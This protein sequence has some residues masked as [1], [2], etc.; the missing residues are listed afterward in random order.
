MTAAQQALHSQRLEYIKANKHKNKITLAAELGMS[1][2][3]VYGMATRYKITLASARKPRVKHAAIL[4]AIYAHPKLTAGKI[5]HKLKIERASVVYLATK[6]N[7]SLPRAQST[8]PR[9]QIMQTENAVFNVHARWCWL[10]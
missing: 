8:A 9:T 4:S 7:I 3:G 6:N 2:S 5:A 1:E 10:I